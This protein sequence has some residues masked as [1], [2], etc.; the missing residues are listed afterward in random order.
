MTLQAIKQQFYTYRNGDLASTLRK[1]GWPHGVIFGLN[2]HQIA[3][4]AG[5]I[6]SPT[7]SLAME[8]WQDKNVRESR[9]LAPYLMPRD[10]GFERALS[11]CKDIVTREE[12][13]MLAFKWARYL[14]CARKLSDTLKTECNPLLQYMAT[15]IDRFIE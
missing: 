7:A 13:D 15:S 10:I 9:M 4:I 2:V 3:S 1:A 5:Q 11:I 14:N 8:L 6:A 12:A